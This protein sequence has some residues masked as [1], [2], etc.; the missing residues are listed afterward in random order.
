MV[1]YNVRGYNSDMFLM[2]ILSWWYGN[3]WISRVHMIKDRLTSL[4]D[5]FSVGLLAS[6]LFAPYKQISAENV[7]GSLNDQMHAFFDKLISRFIGAFVRGFMILIGLVAM[8]LQ[9]IFG[10]VVLIFWLVIPLFPIIGLILM[11][12]GWVPQW[13]I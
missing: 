3:G 1:Y 10:F 11:V 6:T 12:I 8:S 9:I 4:A 7:A 13:I 2:G 5:F